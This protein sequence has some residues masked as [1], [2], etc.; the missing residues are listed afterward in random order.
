MNM[1][2]LSTALNLDYLALIETFSKAFL[3]VLYGATCVFDTMR[4]ET[5]FF[6]EFFLLLLLVSPEKPIIASSAIINEY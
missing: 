1:Y 5:N 6:S 4:N 2:I 3:K